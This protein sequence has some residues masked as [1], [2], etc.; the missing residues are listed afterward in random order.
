MSANASELIVG[1]ESN[2]VIEMDS[3]PAEVNLAGTYIRSV[4]RLLDFLI[5]I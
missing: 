3:N 4:K 2:D 1:Y 5:F